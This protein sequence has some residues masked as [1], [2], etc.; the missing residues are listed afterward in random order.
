[1]Q[2]EKRGP[3]SVVAFNSSFITHHSSLQ[4]RH[5]IPRFRDDPHFPNPIWG[6]SRRRAAPTWVRQNS[7]L[8]L[9]WRRWPRVRWVIQKRE[10]FPGLPVVYSGA[11]ELVHT[12]RYWG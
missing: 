3:R 1:M 7:G 12:P 6:A 2:N 4:Y 9:V 11:G 8:P 10:V 5:V